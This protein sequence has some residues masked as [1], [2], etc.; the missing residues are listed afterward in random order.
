MT[1]TPENTVERTA[2][3]HS[4]S[5]QSMSDIS[6]NSVGTSSA[7]SAF[8][9]EVHNFESTVFVFKLS[10]CY[11]TLCVEANQE[12]SRSDE[13]RELKAPSRFVRKSGCKI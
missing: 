11:C 8:G 5:E 7:K 9:D 10:R 6:S 13:P 12:K 1:R 4:I 2:K 3:R